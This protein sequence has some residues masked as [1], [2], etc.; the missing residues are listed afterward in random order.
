M[1][2]RTLPAIE[3][4]YWDVSISNIWFG[5]TTGKPGMKLRHHTVQD[6]AK[7]YHI[8]LPGDSKFEAVKEFT[9]FFD[10]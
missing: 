6:L 7:R 4:V 9:V 8:M 2:G 10:R 5:R 3:E 1:L